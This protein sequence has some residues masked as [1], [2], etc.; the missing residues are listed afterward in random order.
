M[1]R[2]TQTLRKLQLLDTE[3]SESRS[4]LRDAEALL[5]EP[6][7]LLTARRQQSEAQAGLAKWSARL[8][9]LEM[10]LE[11]LAQ[12]IAGTEK[13]LYGGQVSNPKELGA[14]Q[15]DH[16]SMKTARSKL[17]DQVLE[18]MTGVE[19]SR[20]ALDQA[21]S[22]LGS[23]EERWRREHERTS[24]EVEKLRQRVGVLAENRVALTQLLGSATLGMYEDLLRKKGGRAVVLLVNGM[25]QGCRVTLPSGR[26][27]Q[28]R[29]SE[30]PITCNN[31]GRILVV[32]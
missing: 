29:Q 3:L 19:D 10:D 9:E 28:V 4:K 22:R 18:A 27:Q 5:A 8:R 25:C 20:E 13:R 32:E 2:L 1:A 15:R 26:A 14:L 23:I 11:E 7:D 21:N 30:E 6:Q 31:C 12:K 17:E 24:N 16:D